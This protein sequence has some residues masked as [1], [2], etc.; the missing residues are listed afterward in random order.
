MDRRWG[1]VALCAWLLA[2][3][4]GPAEGT[5][6]LERFRELAVSRL[7]MLEL[8]GLDPGDRAVSELY[9]LVDEE[10]VESLQTGGP[11]ASLAF[12]R[13]RFDG[14]AGAWGGIAFRLRRVPGPSGADLTVAAVT[15]SRLGQL[16]SLRVYTG[17][18]REARLG[19]V[20]TRDGVPALH[21]WPPAPD[22]RA[23]LVV[24][25]T[26]EDSGWGERPVRVE[27][28][29][30]A[31]ADGLRLVWSTA[32]A[33]PEGLWASRH[34]VE[35]GE[36]VIRYGARYAGWTPGCDGQTEHE[37]AYRPAPGTGVP[38]L[39]RRHVWNGWHRELH[40]SVA[41]FFA[42]LQAMDARTLAE[43]VPDPGLRSRL[44]ATLVAEPACEVPSPD[45]PGGVVVA[46]TAQEAGRPAP[47]ALA[48]VRRP[49]GWQL[50]GAG[51]VLQ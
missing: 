6:R 31:G 40:A 49:R 32:A 51:P 34:A 47:W 14:F 17:V 33:F 24:S 18:G 10:V 39:A 50:A 48:W 8:T 28:W 5:D 42:A 37:D 45:R 13:E 12:I 7:G 26:G 20:V 3:A 2:T 22:G 36:I 23:Q 27:L 21:A 9:A 30:A 1:A 35:A 46:A 15:L 4:G 41:R 25:W 29:R 16:N 11:F 43:L 44:P 19:Q 38:T